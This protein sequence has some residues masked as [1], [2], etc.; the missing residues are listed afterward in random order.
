MVDTLRELL[1]TQIWQVSLLIAVVLVFS[2]L[3]SR[4]WPQIVFVLWAVVFIKCVTPPVMQSP[5]GVFSWVRPAAVNQPSHG[6]LT[7]PLTGSTYSKPE[8]NKD[9]HE[10][11][12]HGMLYVDK[13]DMPAEPVNLATSE[14][15]T[16]QDSGEESASVVLANSPEPISPRT[17]SIGNWVLG[18][19]GTVGLLFLFSLWV[20]RRIV[21][22]RIFT[23][24]IETPGW[25]IEQTSLIQH[26]LGV[27]RNVRV[28]VTESEYGPLVTGWIRP[29]IV[30]PAEILKN[31]FR[32]DVGSI[33][34]HE[35][36]HIKR[37]DVLLNVIQT[38]ALALFWFHPLVWW[39]NRQA[40]RLC[41]TC[42]DNEL[43]T[44]L[45]LRRREYAQSLLAV[46]DAK[47]NLR[48]V[49]ATSAIRPAEVTEQRLNAIMKNKFNK[50][51]KKQSLWVWA[52]AAGMLAIVLPAAGT[53]SSANTQEDDGP[54]TITTARTALTQGDL[55][56]AARM[57]R[58][59]VEENDDNAMA[60]HL[61][62]YTLHAQQKIDEAV[63]CHQR[64]A[65]FPQTKV[66]GLY[67]WSCALAL[68]GHTEEALAKLRKSVDAGLDP[69]RVNIEA[70]TDLASLRDTDEFKEIVAELKSKLKS[71]NAM[72]D[73]K[74]WVGKWR[75]INANGKTVGH[76]LITLEESG[77]LIREQWKSANGTTGQ[78]MNYVDPRTKKWKQTWVDS[79][80]QI[81]EFTGQMA[82]GEVQLKGN[83]SLANGRQGKAVMTL[84][85]LA[86]G[87]VHQHMEISFDQG[88]SWK[89]FFDGYYEPVSD[90]MESESTGAESESSEQ[91]G[92]EPTSDS[93]DG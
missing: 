84:K 17:F 26:Q 74:F 78:S 77:N 83:A 19:W 28:V 54:I 53:A 33:L 24:Q 25:L 69:S 42:C 14:V 15:V 62:G 4:R 38:Y 65:G 63:K 49:L 92:S 81:M 46:V 76:N 48:P 79:Q 66:L 32:G 29:M 61:L 16:K 80:G 40:N 85:P 55:D 1:L 58:H 82:N 67:N 37:G 68:Q 11:R 47:R 51:S 87:R 31:S 93:G 56:K 73:F 20:Y 72:D 75:V 9:C 60:W 39:A 36:C 70:D 35:M 90:E 5:V 44:S 3:F 12:N 88:Q 59:L 8:A 7:T 27:E 30:V 86:D 89:T 6:S 13:I 41:E 64:A 50:P 21:F 57:F 10:Q 18:V 52:I 34:A 45:K 71:T 91:A 43:L 22:R 2:Y 23:N